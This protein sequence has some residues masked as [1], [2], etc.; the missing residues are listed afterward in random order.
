MM[1]KIIIP[2]EYDY[3]GV[4]L[5]EA[6]HLSCAYCITRHHGA[7]YGANQYKP[8]S[9]QQWIRGLNR[10][11]L[12]SDVPITL[13]GGEPFL[14]KG[15][16]QILENIRHKVDILTALPPYLTKEH[17]LGLRTLEWNRR[18]APYPLI[19]VSYHGGQNDYKK[20]IERIADLQE[21]LSIGLFYLD[22]PATAHEETEQIR[23]F[24]Q[25]YGVE[26]RSKEF[27]GWWQGRQYGTILYDRAC[28]GTPVGIPVL[29]RNSVVPIAPDGTIFR[30]HSDLYFHRISGAIGH[31]LDEHIELPTEH[32]ICHHFG[33]CSECDVKVK[34][35]RYQV[36]GYTSADIRFTGQGTACEFE[37]TKSADH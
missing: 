21:I 27:L 32:S 16:W 1:K 30:C 29:C 13:Q 11:D 18:E 4:F 10:L 28:E 5:T 7:S 20:L 33:L 17:F 26:V 23:E 36:Y 22:Y 19:R 9:P 24:A 25:R 6:C 14:Y 31:I 35:N 8:L 3:V 12:P 2:D 34:T 37:K 15:I